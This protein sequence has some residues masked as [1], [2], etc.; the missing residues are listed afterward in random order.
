MEP[1]EDAPPGRKAGFGAT[2]RAVFWS[3]FGVRKRKD[4]EHDA[5]HLSE[6]ERGLGVDGEESLLDGAHVGPELLYQTLDAVADFQEPRREALARS[7]LHRPELDE[8]VAARVAVNHAPA[9]GLA[10]G[11]YS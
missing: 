4:Y 1:D 8:T 5:A 3:F 2:M 7:R 10:A 6:L 11:V 9:R